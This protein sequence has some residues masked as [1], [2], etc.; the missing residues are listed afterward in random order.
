MRCDAV[1]HILSYFVVSAVIIGM[2]VLGYAADKIGRWVGSLIT[3]EHENLRGV[4]QSWKIKSDSVES[5][6]LL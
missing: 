5:E 4:S 3:A 6:P 1:W 2:I